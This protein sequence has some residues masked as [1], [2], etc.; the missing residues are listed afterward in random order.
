MDMKNAC[1]RNHKVISLLGVRLPGG[2]FHQPA[3]DASFRLGGQM[4]EF[5]QSSHLTFKKK[6][7]NENFQIAWYTFISGLLKKLWCCQIKSSSKCA[8]L[9]R[10]NVLSYCRNVE[11]VSIR[12]EVRS[13]LKFSALL[14]SPGKLKRINTISRHVRNLGVFFGNQI[15]SGFTERSICDITQPKCW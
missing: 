2:H 4:W 11:W 14:S 3:A 1:F 15:Y 7:C 13:H 6:V 8:A 12:V 9:N 5:S 10:N